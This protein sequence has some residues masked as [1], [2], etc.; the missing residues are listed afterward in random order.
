QV[1]QNLVINAKQAMPQG[2][3]IALRC[4]NIPAEKAAALPLLHGNYVQIVIKD[5]GHGILKEHLDKIFDPYFT[6]KAE[7]TGLGLA[8][9]YAIIKKHDGHIEVESTHGTGTTFT[10]SLPA[11]RK[12]RDN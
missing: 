8:A 12:G 5:E 4:Q 10:I 3:K 7:G 11:S 6:T 1:I 2:G 9:S